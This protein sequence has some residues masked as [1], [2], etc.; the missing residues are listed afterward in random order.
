MEEFEV[1]ME[2]SLARIETKI[3]AFTKTMEDH[4]SRLRALEAKPARRWD[5]LVANVIS[6]LV[7]AAVGYFLGGGKV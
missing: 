5:S 7:A 6:I 1:K 3:D 4:E 2:S